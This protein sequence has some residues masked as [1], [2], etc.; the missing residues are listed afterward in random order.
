MHLISH[1]SNYLVQLKSDFKLQALVTMQKLFSAEEI[2]ESN[3]RI[4][5]LIGPIF[6]VIEIWG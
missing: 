3:F 6:K 2:K 5:S 1:F 4:P